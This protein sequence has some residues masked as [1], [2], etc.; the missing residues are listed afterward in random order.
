M[1]FSSLD[2]TLLFSNIAGMAAVL[3]KFFIYIVPL[4]SKFKSSFNLETVLTVVINLWLNV[5]RVRFIPGKGFCVPAVR[6]TP[7]YQVS[8]LMKHAESVSI[9]KWVA[10]HPEGWVGVIQNKRL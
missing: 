6:G 3:F 1:T 7:A 8:R 10:E 4:K 2:Y 5:S 9:L